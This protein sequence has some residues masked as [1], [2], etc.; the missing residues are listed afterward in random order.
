MEER[1]F[2]LGKYAF[3]YGVTT[4]FILALISLLAYVPVLAPVVWLVRIIVL[5]W[6]VL[7][8]VRRYR[9]QYNQGEL[10]FGQGF[11]LTLLL[12]VYVGVIAA[13]YTGF[14][15]GIMS[16]KESSQMFELLRDAYDQAGID[17]PDNVIYRIINVIPY[18]SSFCCF[19]GHLILGV[20]VGLIF[21]ASLK[22][23][24]SMRPDA[25][26]DN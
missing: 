4:G 6:L 2:S 16:A 22:R 10:T 24:D 12:F 14:Q 19:L 23:D 13:I 9:D 1:E 18:I 11:F 20:L 3:Y 5:V 25:G 26:N 17:L 8:F 21:S 15:A 7:Y